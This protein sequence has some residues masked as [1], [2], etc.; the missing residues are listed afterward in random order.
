MAKKTLRYSK[1]L[2]HSV[3]GPGT[4]ACVSGS[5]ATLSGWSC[6]DGGTDQ[7]PCNANG[8]SAVSN[9]TSVCSGDGN[10]AVAGGSRA[11]KSGGVARGGGVNCSPAGLDSANAA[12]GNTCIDGAGI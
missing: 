4:C 1:P 8:N 9:A 5:A 6:A 2:L 11:C 3:S 10:K 7:G 12:G